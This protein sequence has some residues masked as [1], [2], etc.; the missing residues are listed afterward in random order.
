MRLLV[1]LFLAS[2]L[3]TALQPG[4]RRLG[5]GRL[6]GDITLRIGGRAVALPF[7]SSVVLSLLIFFVGRLLR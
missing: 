7:G 4:L 2:V 5:L 1:T 6:P 3:L